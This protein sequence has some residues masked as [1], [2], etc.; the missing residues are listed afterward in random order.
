M[1]PGIIY[2]VTCTI[3]GKSYIGQTRMPLKKRWR[4]HVNRALS[5]SKYALKCAIRKYGEKSFI[6]EPLAEWDH[7]SD[8]DLNASELAYIAKYDTYRNGYN[9]TIGGDGASGLIHTDKS[10]KR[11]SEFHT[12]KTLSEE[13]KR[14]IGEASKGHIKSDETI[15][16]LSESKTGVKIHTPESKR[17]IS[18]AKRGKSIHTPESKR[19]IAEGNRRAREKKRH[20][21]NQLTFKF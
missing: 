19:R 12:G 8:Y 13:H 1:K 4:K 21:S 6:I 5:G 14:K 7:I 15:Q 18:E 2:R 3:S 10:R 20:N 11:M 17:K 9:M 16:K